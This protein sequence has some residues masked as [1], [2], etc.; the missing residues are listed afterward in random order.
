[1]LFSK[2]LNIKQDH[3]IRLFDINNRCYYYIKYIKKDEYIIINYEDLDRKSK[4]QFLL[5]N[6]ELLT[7]D[8][9]YQNEVEK[10][11]TDIRRDYLYS[12]GYSCDSFEALVREDNIKGNIEDS[13][14]NYLDN[15]L[16]EDNVLIGIHRVGNYFTE[17]I[18]NDIFNNGLKIT[19]HMN[20]AITTKELKNNVSYYPNNKTIKKELLY[21]NS[22]KS[23]L[24]SI[25]IRIP[26]SK[27]EENSD[28]LLVDGND[29]RLNPKY[30]IGYVPVYENNTINNIVFNNN[31]INDKTY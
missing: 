19:G 18:M 30:I 21:A 12:L 26:D 3:L 9:L 8:I 7:N 1:M 22:Y 13:I 5:D 23:S 16:A 28:I 15:L 2:K 25:L 20:G 24:G 17:D 29:I 6:K 4:K 11:K 10:Y 14:N 31:Y 27:L